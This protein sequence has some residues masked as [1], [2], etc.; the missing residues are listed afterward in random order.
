MKINHHDNKQTGFFFL[1]EQMLTPSYD[2]VPVKV[3][4]LGKE[5]FH[6]QSEK[7]EA[8]NEEPEVVGH[9][10]VVKENHHRFARHLHGWRDGLGGCQRSKWRSMF[11]TYQ[12]LQ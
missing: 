4:S 5:R 6:Q 3:A 10:T 7:V 9:D 8:L 2:G 12:A 11:S 1:G